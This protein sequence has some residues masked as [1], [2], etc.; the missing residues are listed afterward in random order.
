M[1]GSPSVANSR[2]YELLIQERLHCSA[3]TK[4]VRLGEYQHRFVFAQLL[5]H[6]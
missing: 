1:M 4:R 2:V 6:F 3:E 5:D